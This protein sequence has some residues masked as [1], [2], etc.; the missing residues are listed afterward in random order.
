V[1]LEASL[2]F[3]EG[4][5]LASTLARIYRACR[6]SLTDATKTG[7]VQKLEEIRAAISTIAYAWQALSID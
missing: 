7:D 5:H 2:D 1:A 3:N 4:G 6:I